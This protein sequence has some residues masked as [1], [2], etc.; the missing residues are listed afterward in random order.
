MLISQLYVNLPGSDTGLRAVRYAESIIIHIE[1][2]PDQSDGRIYPP[3]VSIKYAVA[4]AADY[5]ADS[6]VTV[7]LLSLIDSSGVNKIKGKAKHY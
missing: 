3:Y 6:N 7:L 4:T 1:L 5:E 2:R